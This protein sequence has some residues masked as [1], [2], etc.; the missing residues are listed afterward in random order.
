MSGHASGDEEAAAAVAVTTA[1]LTTFE[2][3][4][5]GEGEICDGATETW[6]FAAELAG[7]GL[8]LE[9][10]G[11]ELSF[12]CDVVETMSVVGWE[13]ALELGA[14]LSLELPS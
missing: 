12:A 11:A 3:V 6:L 2:S 7:A 8:E 5:K 1:L 4:W 9:L 14:A 10:V 13:L